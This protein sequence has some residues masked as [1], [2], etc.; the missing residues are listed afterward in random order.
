M[1]SWAWRWNVFSETMFNRRSNRGTTSAYFSSRFSLQYTHHTL[2]SLVDLNAAFFQ[3]VTFV[4]SSHPIGWLLTQV[5]WRVRKRIWQSA[6]WEGERAIPARDKH[7]SPAV[8][9]QPPGHLTASQ[10]AASCQAAHPAPFC[11]APFIT[12]F[13]V[14]F[15]HRLPWST[16][17][18][19]HCNM[20][21]PCDECRRSDREIGNLHTDTLEHV[22]QSL[23]RWNCTCN[24]TSTYA[25]EVHY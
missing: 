21:L 25:S 19:L 20:Q 4:P 22:L 18:N 5:V 15:R 11:K 8:H 14:Y 3:L 17:N 6:E 23:A 13:T 2:I 24:I 9:P 7:S 16:N 1:K 12:P 10:L